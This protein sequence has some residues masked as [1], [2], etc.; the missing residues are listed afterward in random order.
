M[1]RPQPEN[2]MTAD[3]LMWQS[4]I[5]LVDGAQGTAVPETNAPLDNVQA[6]NEQTLSDVCPT[7]SK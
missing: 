7:A 3:L 1:L 6:S 5:L 2:V 4:T